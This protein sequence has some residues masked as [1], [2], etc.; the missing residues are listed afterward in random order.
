MCKLKDVSYLSLLSQDRTFT[1]SKLCQEDSEFE[2][3]KHPDYQQRVHQLVADEQEEESVP[4]IVHTEY[5]NACTSQSWLMFVRDVT[6][7]DTMLEQKLKFILLSPSN[8]LPCMFLP[9][10]RY[11]GLVENVRVRQA[12]YMPIDSAMISSSGATSSS[13]PVPLHLAQP[14]PW[15]QG[16]YQ[17]THLVLPDG[18][19][20]GQWEGIS[21]CKGN[22]MTS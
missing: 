4:L 8:S 19:E 2:V 10:V 9:Q 5:S 12:G 1:T 3:P 17:G 15:Q 18:G 16:R 13:A 20:G 21:P 22:A 14:S 7:N 6:Y 11:F